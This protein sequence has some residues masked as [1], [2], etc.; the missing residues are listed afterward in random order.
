M[1]EHRVFLSLQPA[2]LSRCFGGRVG[3]EPYLLAEIE[4]GLSWGV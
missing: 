2:I 1:K 4:I 3:V